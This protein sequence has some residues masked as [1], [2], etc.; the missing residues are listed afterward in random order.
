MRGKHSDTD[1]YLQRSILR[2]KQTLAGF[3]CLLDNQE[4]IS[5]E[6]HYYRY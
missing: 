6:E 1:V 4:E 2:K 5:V 3:T